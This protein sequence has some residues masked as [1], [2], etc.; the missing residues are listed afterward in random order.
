M[1]YLHKTTSDNTIYRL[2]I[3]KLKKEHNLTTKDIE[4]LK[5]LW[6]EEIAG[7]NQNFIFQISAEGS[8]CSLL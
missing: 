8:N 2:E 5:N 6:E 7:I 1:S 4:D 3:E